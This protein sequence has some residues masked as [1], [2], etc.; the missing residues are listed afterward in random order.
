[1]RLVIKRTE[2][3]RTEDSDASAVG[4]DQQAVHLLPCKIHTRKPGSDRQTSSAPVDRYFCPY[5]KAETDDKAALWHSSFRGKPL[6]GVKLGIPDGYVGVLCVG[7]EG[8]SSGNAVK[9]STA[10][11]ESV[12]GEVI[13][14]LMYWNWDRVPTREDP[15]L[16]ALDWMR[17]SEAI[18]S[19]ND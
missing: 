2:N 8:V 13:Q 7:E 6:T 9:D 16:S 19:N 3:K 17:V 12:S 14:Q 1:M 18:M 15:L 11:E 5:T 10:V 4:T